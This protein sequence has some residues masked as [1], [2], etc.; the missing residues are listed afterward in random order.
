MV[1]VV[2]ELGLITCGR[3]FF[4]PGGNTLLWA[5]TRQVFLLGVVHM[6]EG[7]QVRVQVECGRE[8]VGDREKHGERQNDDT[9]NRQSTTHHGWHEDGMSARLQTLEP[10]NV[11]AHQL[12]GVNC[13]R[14]MTC[15]VYRVGNS[16]VRYAVHSIF[17]MSDPQPF[18]SMSL[19]MTCCNTEMNNSELNGFP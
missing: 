8:E 9:R 6:E 2:K 11:I 1:E 17:F 4:S 13:M 10:S 12:R 7:V 16:E 18:L 19:S 15:E 14:K 3:R 5:K